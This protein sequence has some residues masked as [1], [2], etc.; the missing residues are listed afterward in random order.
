M[1]NILFTSP[2]CFTSSLMR[3]PAL[4]RCSLF[5]S[6]ESG[7]SDSSVPLLQSVISN[8]G[9]ELSLSRLA[10]STDDQSSCG[11]CYPCPRRTIPCLLAGSSDLW[12]PCVDC[13]L[14][15]ADAVCARK[16][17]YDPFQ[18]STSQMKVDISRTKISF[19]EGPV[20]TE[21]VKI[22]DI[23]VTGRFFSL[24]GYYGWLSR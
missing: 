7:V 24:C 4:V 21:V 1:K 10:L 14:I 6:G 22:I 15:V 9:I 2:F 18:S 3:F 19:I 20:F 11:T 23:Q 5:S 16:N 17:K 12:E 8:E 13:W